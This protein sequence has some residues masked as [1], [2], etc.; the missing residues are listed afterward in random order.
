MVRKTNF[1]SISV[2][3]SAIVTFLTKKSRSLWIFQ[4]CFKTT[5]RHSLTVCGSI[6][7]E[8]LFLLIFIPFYWFNQNQSC[9]QIQIFLWICPFSNMVRKTNFLSISVLVSAIVTLMSKKKTSL[10]FPPKCFK[11]TE[12]HSLAVCV[13]LCVEKQFLLIFIPIYWV[14][15]KKLF[16]Q[17]QIFLRI[18]PFSNMVWITNFLSKSVLVSDIVTFM[19]KNKSSLW[20]S[21]KILQNNRKA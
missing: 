10:R 11:T 1:L 5:E 12:R 13:P 15:K 17:I 16:K 21:P 2:L 4:N 7:E 19:F 3:V 20:I 14:D 18:C 9:K 6:W 8:K